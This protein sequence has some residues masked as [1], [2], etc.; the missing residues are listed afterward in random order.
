MPFPKA[1]YEQYRDR[2][3]VE[4]YRPL[5]NATLRRIQSLRALPRLELLTELMSEKV[6]LGTILKEDPSHALGLLPEAYATFSETAR[7]CF[8][9]APNVTQLLAAILLW[10]GKVVEMRS[11]EG[12]TL[13]AAL[14]CY[15]Q[16]LTGRG[17]HM[18]TTN[19]YLAE[20]DKEW[21]GAVF[22]RLGISC[23]VVTQRTPREV[24]KQEYAKDILYA[25]NQ[26]VGF[27][28]L[29]DNLVMREDEK[30]LRGFP[31]AII[32]EADS[33]LID[34]A[35]TSLIISNAVAPSGFAL[36]PKLLEIVGNLEEGKDYEVD[37]RFKNVDFT[38][39]GVGKIVALLGRDIFA[40]GD[41][42]TVQQLRYAL[43]ARVFYKQD[44]EYMI[45]DGKLILIDE[46]TGH[47][48]W[49]YRLLHGLQQVVEMSAG[50]PMSMENNVIASITYRNLYGKYQKVGGMSG[51]AL[52]A[53]EEFLKLYGLEVFAMTPHHR[54]ARNDLPVM[55]FRTQEEKLE[56]I[57]R[58]IEE[59][60]GRGTPVLAVGRS[61]AQS[62]QFSALLAAR[63]LP[64]QLLHAAVTEKEF[65][66][67][68]NA[69]KR[70]AITVA[71]N[72]AGRGADII[73]DQEFKE[74]NGLAVYGLE[75]NLSRRIDDQLRGRAGR[76]GQP[77]ETSIFASLTDE[78]FQVYAD[79]ALWDYAE[80][81]SWSKS[82]VRDPKLEALLLATQD[83]AESLAA[84]ERQVAAEFERQVAIGRE[85]ADFVEEPAASA[86]IVKR[87]DSLWK[88]ALSSYGRGERW[89]D[90]WNANR[91]NIR[92]PD[93]IY[94]GQ[95]LV[96][97]DGEVSQRASLN[98]AYAF[99]TRERKTEIVVP[100]DF[101]AL[102]TR[103]AGQAV[104]LAASLEDLP[105]TVDGIASQGGSA[106]ANVPTEQLQV[107]AL[108][109]QNLS[110]DISS[111]PSQIALTDAAA[112][113]LGV[114]RDAVR[115]ADNFNQ[116]AVHATAVTVASS[117]IV[118]QTAG[119]AV[120]TGNVS[121]TTASN[122]A[123]QI[124]A[125]S[126]AILGSQGSVLPAT[127][128][129][130]SSNNLA[131][132]S[133]TNA[134]A[135]VAA[136]QTEQAVVQAVLATEAAIA[137]NIAAPQSQVAANA[138]ESAGRAIVALQSIDPVEVQRVL[139]AVAN[140][141]NQEILNQGGD[142]AGNAPGPSSSGMSSQ[143]SSVSSSDSTSQTSDS[144][145]QSSFDTSVTGSTL[146]FQSGE[147]T[148]GHITANPP[149]GLIG[150]G[151]TNLTGS[152]VLGTIA[153]L[154]VG[155]VNLFAGVA[156]T[157]I[158]VGVNLA[159]GQEVSLSPFSFA[160]TPQQ[161]W[162]GLS[163]TQ[164]GFQ[165]QRAGEIAS[166]NAPQTG[167]IG[168]APASASG[169][170]TGA[171]ADSEADAAMGG[172]TAPAAQVASAQGVSQTVSDIGSVSNDPAMAVA[173]VE[174]SLDMS[175]MAAMLG[176]SAANAANAIGP[177]SQEAAIASNAATRA[178][179]Q[180]V[181]VMNQADIAV[182][183]AANNEVDFAANA[184]VAARTA[185]RSAQANA[186]MART[187]LSAL[188]GDPD[189]KAFL[190]TLTQ[191]QQM[192][193]QAFTSVFGVPTP[194]AVAT[195]NVDTAGM[196]SSE[197]G[198][199][200]ADVDTA[201]AAEMG[202]TGAISDESDITLGVQGVVGSAY[203]AVAA[204]TAEESATALGMTSS[205]AGSR[206]SAD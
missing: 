75:P 180:N 83:L 68:G 103:V 64:H 106:S 142:G 65:D 174:N 13:T 76:Q 166:Q 5:L 47:P 156:N 7:L 37:P 135:A 192:M 93:L 205:E 107:L 189:A 188:R 191:N 119:S 112:G 150:Q 38:D 41:L 87:G 19:D 89:I 185:A 33:I 77:G 8:G 120:A 4:S 171:N 6:R 146:S 3:A 164:Q 46:F 177:N 121:A 96:M 58:D 127:V 73:L 149:S 97:P 32:D 108:K 197:V 139:I 200:S 15:L 126:V 168:A 95:G 183:A 110:A 56:F 167:N 49:D 144:T 24:R 159:T 44:R 100:S 136:G 138:S 143:G 104:T 42:E 179:A 45:R 52:T 176:R 11:G 199:T 140:S 28:Y 160:T 148:I 109:A 53:Q 187:A 60:H 145:S 172:I 59:R 175:S 94:Q 196:T 30:V 133:A 105:K 43:Y 74:Q 124:K 54:V 18:I 16:A 182:A 35:R 202:E 123:V 101:V 2:R 128:T 184:A 23:G 169:G 118:S 170:T 190:A 90:V 25:S 62:G 186:N 79:R 152:N 67:I 161:A 1:L 206:T 137:A 125:I 114:A 88:I 102:R 131:Q 155:V 116:G 48:K 111:A 61:V 132:I 63:G 157:A 98:H 14:P 10:H 39:A 57:V 165:T 130:E 80:H 141:G 85:A 72:M 29:R 178:E 86:Y 151:V 162:S 92:E 158:G 27:D 66:I 22:N 34:E 70:G 40:G 84:E 31:F 9:Y 194:A 154:A 134:E 17:M 117:L 20:R 204:A 201:T 153:N 181:T 69:G 55:F 193:D 36:V 12:K 147:N 50:V 81:V 198:L 78:L 21:M 129:A 71:T 99:G 173:S 163:G 122:A 203:S 91:E 115:I 51:T 82:G 26:E 195:E 113:L